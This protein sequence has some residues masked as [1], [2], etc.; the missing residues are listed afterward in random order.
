MKVIVASGKLPD[1]DASLSEIPHNF[2]KRTNL[3]LYQ[4][5]A[6]MKIA[7]QEG[8]YRSRQ[9][10]TITPLP[11]WAIEFQTTRRKTGDTYQIL[12]IEEHGQY[13]VK[14]PRWASIVTGTGVEKEKWREMTVSGPCSL[15][16]V[17]AVATSA[18]L[19]PFGL[20]HRYLVYIPAEVS[21][22]GKSATI[23]VRHDFASE[24]NG[25]DTWTRARKQSDLAIQKW[26]IGAQ[27]Q[28]SKY[29]T[30]KSVGL[31]TERLDYQSTLSGQR[32]NSFRVVHT[33]SRSFYAA[34]LDPKSSTALGLQFD[35]ARIRIIEGGKTI[36]TGD[37]PI[38]G[39]ICD[40]LL[41]SIVVDSQQEAYW[42]TGLFN[43]ET[44]NRLV[45]KQARGEPPGIYTIPV[46]VLEQ[47][48]LVFDS[49]NSTHIELA[50]TAKIL[51]G[52]MHETIRRYLADE[53]GIDIRAI[54]DTDQSQDVPSTISSA[55][56][57]RLD[58]R[59]ELDKLNRLADRLL[60]L[61]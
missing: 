52:H 51:E 28:W 50:K 16:Y 48:N 27:K 25:L 36:K 60:Q 29:K 7:K 1:R 34:V 45:M 13:L 44:F 6:Q 31:I 18:W 4:K 14:T 58:A 32:P 47:M 20:A 43:S 55:L 19:V 26:T 2:F 54:D 49:D 24:G 42:M 3:S 61:K 57:R 17:F 33:R 39:V 56:M 53:K 15:E 38:A 41:H 37:L 8:P 40:N 35:S 9:G 23:T 46:K 22:K 30:E 11:L 10:A 21:G 59:K 12:P 5:S